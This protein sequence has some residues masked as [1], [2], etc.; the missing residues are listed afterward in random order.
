[1]R[2]ENPYQASSAPTG[3]MSQCLPSHHTV[4]KKSPG[5]GFPRFAVILALLL[6]LLVGT[7]CGFYILGSPFKA[8]PATTTDSILLE[9]PALVASLRNLRAS[10]TNLAANSVHPKETIEI[11]KVPVVEEDKPPVVEE[12]KPPV[13]VEDKPPV[14]VEDKP[15]VVVEDKPPVVAEDKP[16]VVE[17]DKP[18]VVVEGNPPVVAEDKPPVVVEDNKVTPEMVAKELN[19]ASSTNAEAFECM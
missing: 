4:E 2:V 11:P 1:M 16:P 6:M 13:V 10:N 9:D 17:E 15:P 18:P 7:I 8:T 3:L 5:I 19:S 12:D 14:V